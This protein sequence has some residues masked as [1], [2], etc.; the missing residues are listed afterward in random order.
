VLKDGRSLSKPSSSHD[1]G[2][3]A[4]KTIKRIRVMF[5]V[6]RLIRL[7]SPPRH[8]RPL[9]APLITAFFIHDNH[10]AHTILFLLLMASPVSL[11]STALT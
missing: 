7:L 6:S 10:Q 2:Q 4:G 11:L 5:D 1:L 9:K 3:L 8:H